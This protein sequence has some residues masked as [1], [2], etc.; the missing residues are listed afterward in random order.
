MRVSFIKGHEKF[1][2]LKDKNLINGD[3][4][5]KSREDA[6]NDHHRQPEVLKMM[7]TISVT[8]N[9]LKVITKLGSDRVYLKSPRSRSETPATAKRQRER[10]L[11]SS[12][13]MI[14]S[15]SQAS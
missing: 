5:D 7:T 15:V 4:V 12:T 1:G 13:E 3:Q 9:S 2:M 8:W 11:Q 14:L 6:S 10:F